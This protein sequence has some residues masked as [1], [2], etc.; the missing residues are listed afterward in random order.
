MPRPHLYSFT[1]LQ[2]KN[3]LCLKANVNFVDRG[4]AR[5]EVGKSE[6]KIE[7][8]APLESIGLI[9]ARECRIKVVAYASNDEIVLEREYDSDSFGNFDLKIP[10]NKKIDHMIIYETSARAGLELVLGS[11]L[12]LNIPEPKKLLISDFDKTLV[13]TKFSTLKEM[14]YSLRNPVSSFPNVDK[15]IEMFQGY[16]DNGFTPFILSASPHFYEKSI[17]DW[18]YQNKLYAAH[19]FLKD[20]RN[21]FSLSQGILTPKDL[22]K[23]GFYKLTQLVDLLLMTGI[24]DELVL[25]GDAFESDTFIYLTLLSVIADRYDPWKLWGKIKQ[26]RPFLLTS[27]QD[28]QFLTKFYQLS[29]MA[30]KKPLPSFKVLIRYNDT[31]K[32]CREDFRFPTTSMSKLFEDVEFYKA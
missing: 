30:R 5:L 22:K 9:R 4:L 29:E 20:Y 23:Q 15:S 12:P 17:R 19:L 31:K 27:K 8:S 18:I 14:L 16:A 13:D 28:S 10:I 11:Y 6:E 32:V 24:P 1:A 2:T 25:M 21:I 26:E 7:L 3:E